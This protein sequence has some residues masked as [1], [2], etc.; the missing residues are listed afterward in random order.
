M[1]KTRPALAVLL[2]MLLLA[3]AAVN[4]RAQDARAAK[5]VLSPADFTDLKGARLVEAE[6]TPSGQAVLMEKA[7]GWARSTVKLGEGGRIPPGFYNITV[8]LGSRDGSIKWAV[9][10][11]LP[12]IR[13]GW[14]AAFVRGGEPNKF[15]W[16]QTRCTFP[17]HDRK[18]ITLEV[19]SRGDEN[20]YVGEVVLE[21]TGHL[22]PK[23]M[24]SDQEF[25][26]GLDRDY[27]GLGA[28]MAAADAKDYDKACSELVKYLQTHPRKA[29]GAFSGQ[30]ATEALTPT[31]K[32][33]SEI[34]ELLLDDKMKLV[35]DPRHQ[36]EYC[37]CEKHKI[38]PTVFSFADPYEWHKLYD[39]PG[40]RWYGWFLTPNLDNL[41][42]AYQSTGDARF[43][44]KA[45]DLVNRW[46]EVWGPFPKR[47]V[48]DC[49]DEYPN[50]YYT[51]A[52][53]GKT[54]TA[55]NWSRSSGVRHGL[56]EAIW[57]VL[58]T[59]AA[60][61]DITNRERVEAL[62]QCLILARFVQNVYGGQNA[63]PTTYLWLLQIGDWLPEFPEIRDMSENAL[64]SFLA[65]MDESF[66]PDGAYFE[67][68]YYRHGRYVEAAQLA[69]RQGKDISKF[70]DKFR[71][72]FD[73][74]LWMTNPMGSFPWINDAGGGQVVDQPQPKTPEYASLAL[75]L[76]PDD[77]QLKYIASF[78][79]EGE[80]PQP[81]SRN[82]DWCGFMIM[83]SGWK[84]D[85]LH[86]VFDGCR[87]TGSHNHADQMNIVVSAYGSTLLCDGGYPNEFSA[88]ERTYYL[89]HPRSHNLVLVDQMMQTPEAVEPVEGEVMAGW[90]LWGNTPRNNYWVSTGGYD[91][92][93]THYDRAYRKDYE[94]PAVS[95]QDARQ[96]RRILFLKPQT[97]TPYWVLYDIVQ[98]KNEEAKEHSLQALFHFTPASSAQVVA[99]GGA[100]RNT[101]ENAGLLIMPRSE[102]QWRASI[103]KGDA[104][105]QE[106]YW[107]GFI[108]GGYGKPLVPTECGIFEYNGPLP[109]S[110][111][112][113]LYPYPRDG[114]TE[115][116][117][118]LITADRDG[119]GLPTDQ[120]LGLEV[121]LQSGKDTIVA[122]AMP[123]AMT[124]CGELCSDA[125]AAVV[126]RDAKG[127]IRS[128]LL[129][130]GSSLKSGD[131][132]LVDTGGRKARYLECGVGAAAA[133]QGV[134]LGAENVAVTGVEWID[135][136]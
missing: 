104:R 93:E 40:R 124:T 11:R 19:A 62:K 48:Y 6:G 78:G 81:T 60:C 45:M 88:P 44:R 100:I 47:A 69:Q 106:K 59:T 99:E 18:E 110:V 107:Q 125:R 116:G 76:Y 10:Q 128:I 121:T 33:P 134:T 95:V 96:E 3:G 86:L 34:A 123:G 64:Y 2:G 71:P 112:T 36:G 21:P 35:W 115:A 108:S 122:S 54:G 31:G 68:C 133:T 37:T 46:R 74:N 75:K 16:R 82:F 105:P 50:D 23:E 90:R 53:W 41:I 84:P 61:P 29:E 94:Q 17:L 58:R 92:A 130:E 79:A 114:A 97:G 4:C 52:S 136:Q 113:V 14:Y 65:F 80:P 85:D 101:A 127:T 9:V 91:Y 66:F 131:R 1:R 7:Y 12:V 39:Y 73:F 5:L 102:R 24:M 15:A 22:W 70:L 49:P 126:R 38:E 132:V 98:P 28:V 63:P 42:A 55:H 87:N 135:K 57:N 51:P 25:F 119:K 43:A 27:P 30:F 8:M 26:G 118:R 13:E 89:F 103:V 120:A 67:L 129:V 56:V 32:P 83:R 111:A 77:P 20:F 117:C 109:V 72:R